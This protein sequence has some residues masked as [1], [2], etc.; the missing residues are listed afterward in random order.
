MKER[1]T[2]NN[3]T[4]LT[5]REYLLNDNRTKRANTPILA[6]KKE[7]Q[8]SPLNLTDTQMQPHLYSIPSEQNFSAVFD[9]VE[10][11][12]IV[13]MSDMDESAFLRESIQPGFIQTT[14]HK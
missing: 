10:N 13:M 11:N 14:S 9:N 4:L 1:K 3:V 6:R 8:L 5:A 2:N 7:E 12:P